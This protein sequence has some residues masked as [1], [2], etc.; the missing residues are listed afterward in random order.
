[1]FLG[2]I[3]TVVAL[4][5]YL[6]VARRMYI[7][8]P[9]RTEPVPVPFLLG[10]AIVICIVGVVGMGAYPG[11]WVTATQRAAASV[12]TSSSPGTR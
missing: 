4:Y 10:A 11:P 8:E 7:E 2:A 9:V 12:F 1:V 3:L 6:V 5:Y